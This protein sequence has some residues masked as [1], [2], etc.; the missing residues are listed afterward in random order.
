MA[1][2][3]ISSLSL[4]PWPPPASPGM[5]Q[6]VKLNYQII[7]SEGATIASTVTCLL[8]VVAIVL[9]V[10]VLGE[11][12]TVMVLAG[13]V[14]VLVGAALNDAHLRHYA[15]LYIVPMYR[16]DTSPICAAWGW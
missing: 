6:V 1:K 2:P 10:L 8:P 5:S 7:T 9:G 12:V 3:A 4:L 16:P 14:L 11:N 15:T 13:I